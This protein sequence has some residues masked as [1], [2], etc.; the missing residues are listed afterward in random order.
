MLVL[1]RHINGILLS[2]Y[3]SSLACHYFVGVVPLRMNPMM[4]RK[5]WS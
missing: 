1:I 5:Q 4:S 3:V 2:N